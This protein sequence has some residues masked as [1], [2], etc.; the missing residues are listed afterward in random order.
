[1][2]GFGAVLAAIKSARWALWLYENRG[3]LKWAA[4]G[5]AF[6]ALTGLWRWEHHDRIAAESVAQSA[7]E[8]LSLAQQ[9]AARWQQ[10][11]ALRDL[12]IV[13]LHVTLA[14][15]SDAVERWRLSSAN[16]DAAARIAAETDRRNRAAADAR[17]RELMEEARARPEAVRPLGPLVLTRVDGLFD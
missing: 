7:T 9:D 8:R 2:L 14:A 11:S 4:V 16:A 13:E 6:A 17:I 1:M 15:Q 5:I 12:A 3:W 10:A